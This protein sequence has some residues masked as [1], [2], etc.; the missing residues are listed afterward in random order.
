MTGVLRRGEFAF[1]GDVSRPVELEFRCRF[2]KEL[3]TTVVGADFERM[4]VAR[5]DE[6]LTR[7]DLQ[8]RRLLIVS[9][10]GLFGGSRPLAG[11]VLFRR[12]LK[13]IQS[14]RREDVQLAMRGDGRGPALFLRGAVEVAHRFAAF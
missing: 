14:V 3:S 6:Q 1:R 13:A 4:L 7:D 8:L 10:R 11:A 2:L 5:G 12:V 9:G